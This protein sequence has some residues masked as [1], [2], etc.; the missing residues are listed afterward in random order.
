MWEKLSKVTITIP[1]RLMIPTYIVFGFCVALAYI[2][3][4][5]GTFAG[6]PALRYQR[7]ILPWP[8]WGSH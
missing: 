6:S 3:N 8:I 7:D 5:G 1:S 2:L 4:P